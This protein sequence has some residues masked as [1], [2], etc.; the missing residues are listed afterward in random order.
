MTYI[1]ER[2]LYR[3]TWVVASEHWFLWRACRK[4]AKAISPQYTSTIWRIVKDDVVIYQVDTT[5]PMIQTSDDPVDAKDRAD[6]LAEQVKSSIRRLNYDASVK[7]KETSEFADLIA[8][9]VVLRLA[10]TEGTTGDTFK[11][12][13]A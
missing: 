7:R 4:I 9:R 3:E 8:D 1:V 5:R 11:E 2:K 12:E 13:D 10:A 6:R